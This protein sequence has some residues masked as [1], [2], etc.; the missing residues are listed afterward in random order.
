LELIF[1]DADQVRF[2]LAGNG[3]EWRN[4]MIMKLVMTDGSFPKIPC[5]KFSTSKIS[6]LNSKDAQKI[7]IDSDR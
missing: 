7:M 5:V 4:G 2:V 1:A 3:W 6:I